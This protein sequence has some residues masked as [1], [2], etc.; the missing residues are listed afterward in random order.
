MLYDKTGLVTSVTQAPAGVNDQIGSDPNG[1]PRPRSFTWNWAGGTMSSGVYGYDGAGN[2][3]KIGGDTYGYDSALRLIQAR[4]GG[5]T[6]SFQYDALGNM[7]AMGNRTFTIDFASNHV[8]SVKVGQ[9]AAQPILY[10]DFRGNITQMPDGR[11]LQPPQPNASLTQLYDPFNNMIYMAGVDGSGIGRVFVYD[12]NDERI[13][14]INFM[15]S[16]GRRELWSLRDA[17]NRILRDFERTYTTPTTSILRWKKDY[18]YRGGA[19]SNTVGKNDDDVIELHDVHV[20][21]LGSVRYVTGPDGRLLNASSSGAKYTPYG[22]LP[23]DQNL[24]G[25]HRKP[26]PAT[27]ETT[28]TLPRMKRMSTTCTPVI[29]VRPWDGSCRWIWHAGRL[30]LRN[31]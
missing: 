1:F 14:V 23:I 26:S 10:G 18:I 12:G 16:A 15:A 22:N 5:A 3:S 27:N 8:T 2:I 19:L 24:P 31:R 13:G 29:T 11:A 28:T 25:N 6:E 30:F 9:A 7:T 21:H 20:D 17:G 4:V